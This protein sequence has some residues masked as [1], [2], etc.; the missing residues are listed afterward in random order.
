MLHCCSVTQRFRMPGKP[1][2]EHRA[3]IGQGLLQTQLAAPP[4]WKNWQRR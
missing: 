2:K 4:R 3:V 1:G